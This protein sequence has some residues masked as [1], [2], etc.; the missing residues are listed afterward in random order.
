M[1]LW[2]QTFKKWKQNKKN[3]SSSSF[4]NIFFF[5]FLNSC[6]CSF[7]LCEESLEIVIFYLESPSVLIWVL[8]SVS[9]QLVLST[10]MSRLNG[11]FI[12][13]ED[14]CAAVCFCQCVKLDSSHSCSASFHQPFTSSDLFSF[15]FFPCICQNG[16]SQC[17]NV[18][19]SLGLFVW[20]SISAIFSGLN[21]LF[22][23]VSFI[24]W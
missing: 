13:L 8:Y 23:S 6:S 21:K 9:F 22:Q 10:G 15:L 1:F 3:K 18:K 11:L 5:S 19:V 24:L 20:Y 4:E 2:K 7:I 14:T 12:S 17:A 16:K